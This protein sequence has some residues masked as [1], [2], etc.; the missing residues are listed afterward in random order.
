MAN[1]G[2]V[3]L[4]DKLMRWRPPNGGEMVTMVNDKLELV[5]TLRAPVQYPVVEEEKK[6]INSKCPHHGNT[7]HDE[8]GVCAPLL[9]YLRHQERPHYP[10]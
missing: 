9:V 6:A 2:S 4:P 8:H 1:S 10:R 3:V 7:D 5:Y